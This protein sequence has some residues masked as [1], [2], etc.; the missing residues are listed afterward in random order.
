LAVLRV[1]LAVPVIIVLTLV[2]GIASLA[3][4]VVDPKGKGGHAI[5][6]LWAACLLALLGVRV[7]TTLPAEGLP[8]PALFAANH[9]SA[10]DIPIVLAHLPADFRMIHKASLRRIPV[11]GWVLWLGGHVAIDR[12][13]PFRARRSLERAAGRLRDGTS[14][15][16]FPEGTRS[17]DAAVRH[18]KR[19]SFVL[20]TEAAVPVVPISLVGVKKVVPRGILTLKPG[21]VRVKVHGAVHT[22]G[23][24]PEGAAELAEEV[25]QMVARG[26]G[27]PV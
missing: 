26:C 21:L 12:S 16:T 1:V 6:R 2:L 20:A 13:N 7:E 25:R 18:F 8:A 23:R 27:E 15:L 11:V 22:E 19:G 14:I 9:G 4:G 10:L 3:V 17:P 5:A 24:S